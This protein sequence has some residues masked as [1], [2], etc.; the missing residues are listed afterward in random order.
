MSESV[1]EKRQEVAMTTQQ[2]IELMAE[3]IRQT[4][5]STSENFKET[6]AKLVIE[7]DFGRGAYF[8]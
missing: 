6:N 2:I 7:L 3:S 8:L 5:A 1:E 4:N